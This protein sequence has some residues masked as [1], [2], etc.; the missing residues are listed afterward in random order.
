MAA[1]SRRIYPDY[2]TC[3]HNIALPYNLSLAVSPQ[4]KTPLSLLLH[5][6]VWKAGHDKID[7][8]IIEHLINLIVDKERRLCLLEDS[9]RQLKE[10][11]VE[12]VNT[13]FQNKIK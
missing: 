4:N 1:I 3:A 2:V 5:D 6:S 11:E 8:P 7:G 13:R 9:K 10:L 12:D